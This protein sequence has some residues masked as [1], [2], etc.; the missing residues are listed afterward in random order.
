MKNDE[1]YPSNWDLGVLIG[2]FCHLAVH[3]FKQV[4]FVISLQSLQKMKNT[5]PK[6]KLISKQ[7]E[8]SDCDSN[9]FD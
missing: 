2:V 5:C 8:S 9:S 7:E 1:T 6:L 3:T 4:P